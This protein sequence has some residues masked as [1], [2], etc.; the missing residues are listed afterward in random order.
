MDLLEEPLKGVEGAYEREQGWGKLGEALSCHAEVARWHGDIPLAQS[1][2]RRALTLP[3]EPPMLWRGASILTVVASEMQAG[4]PEE[5]RRLT[6]AWQ[7]RFETLPI[8]GYSIPAATL[9]VG[10]IALQQCRLHQAQ[11]EYRQLLV[12]AKADPA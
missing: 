9:M 3:P 10:E 5:A 4:R 2:A 8:P 12:T 1:L 11:Q 7:Q 6:L